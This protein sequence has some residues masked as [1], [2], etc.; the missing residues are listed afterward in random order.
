[1]AY[2]TQETAL[3]DKLLDWL[4][5]KQEEGAPLYWEHRSGSG[6]FSYKKGVPDLFVVVSGHHIE[7]ETKAPDGKLSAMQ[8]KFMWRCATQW[9]IP[10]LVPRTFA[11]AKECIEAFLPAEFRDEDAC[12]Q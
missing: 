7:I 6:G 3:A 2:K 11:E 8:E 12:Y 9:H 4:K 5:A 10:H 1:M